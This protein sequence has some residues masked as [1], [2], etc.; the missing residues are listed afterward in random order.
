MFLGVPTIWAIS[1]LFETQR[2]SESGKQGLGQQFAAE[3]N[4]KLSETPWTDNEGGEVI[5]MLKAVRINVS[6]LFMKEQLSIGRL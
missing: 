4:V 1:R 5:P 3:S 2:V 6:R